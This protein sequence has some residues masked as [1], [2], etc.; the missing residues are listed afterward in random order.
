[1]YL[2]GIKHWYNAK[3]I[4]VR[5]KDSKYLFLNLHLIIWGG[6]MVSLVEKSGYYAAPGVNI[7]FTF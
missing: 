1:M 5:S 6:S 7:G 2:F 3:R 4:L